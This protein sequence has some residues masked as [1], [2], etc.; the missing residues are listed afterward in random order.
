LTTFP[1]SLMTLYCYNHRTLRVITILLLIH[2]RKVN[3]SSHYE[4]YEER[5]PTTLIR[6]TMMVAHA[7]IIVLKVF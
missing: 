7:T 4:R 1:F 5:K 3:E 6:L 2:I